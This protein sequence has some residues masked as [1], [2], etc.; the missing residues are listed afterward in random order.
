MAKKRKRNR[1]RTHQ[2]AVKPII[3]VPKRSFVT[4]ALVAVMAVAMGLAVWFSLSPTLEKQQ[5]LSRQQELLDSIQ[6]GD[7]V[8]ELNSAVQAADFYDEETA[9]DTIATVPP[10]ESE[11]EV[12]AAEPIKLVVTG[13]GIL[14]YDRLD[15]K[16]PVTDGVT[17]E[18][19]KIAIG[20]VPETAPIGSEGNAVLAG[21]RSYTYGQFFNRLGEA[22]PGDIIRY[23]DKS[24]AAFSYEVYQILEIEPNDQTAFVQPKGEH[25]LTLYTCTPI[26]TATHRLLVRARL[27]P[28]NLETEESR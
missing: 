7:G 21:H 10:V 28:E 17:V 19:L 20:H 5:E 3:A 24:G 15:M 11:P 4:V 12:P 1:K 6:S 2:P 27:I 18:Q 8:I 25:L 22:E 26:R 9:E 23:E 13:T 16:L 14:T